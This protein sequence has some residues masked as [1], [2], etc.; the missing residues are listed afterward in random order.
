VIQGPIGESWVDYFG[1]LLLS[2][3][4]VDSHI[5]LTMLSGALPDLAA[6]IGLVARVQNRGLTVLSAHYDCVPEVE[7]ET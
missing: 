4:V 6:F 7:Q 5:H 1:D 2:M 3:Q